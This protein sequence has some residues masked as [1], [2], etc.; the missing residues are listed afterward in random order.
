MVLGARYPVLVRSAWP[1][2]QVIVTGCEGR[3]SIAFG[4]MR[5]GAAGFLWRCRR[6][7]GMGRSRGEM[8]SLTVGL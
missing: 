1:A 8:E 4:Q 7:P 5:L 2:S 3:G 6:A